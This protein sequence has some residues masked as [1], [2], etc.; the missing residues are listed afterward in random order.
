MTTSLEEKARQNHNIKTDNQ[1]LW[2][3]G[4]VKTAPCDFRLPSRSR[5]DL[6]SSG[7]LRR[8]YW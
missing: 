2:N 5:W 3:Y 6:R 7:I 1:N 8:V 4:E